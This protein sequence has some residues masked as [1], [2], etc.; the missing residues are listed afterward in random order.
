VRCDDSLDRS[1]DRWLIMQ[2]KQLVLPG[3]IALQ[4]LFYI[5]DQL[6]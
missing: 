2:M 5:D 1:G 3:A 6:W 4:M